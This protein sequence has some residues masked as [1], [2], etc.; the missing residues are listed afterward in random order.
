MCSK[1]TSTNDSQGC[2]IAYTAPSR[3]P[4]SDFPLHVHLHLYAIEEMRHPNYRLRHEVESRELTFLNV[5]D[6]YSTSFDGSSQDIALIVGYVT[7]TISFSAIGL[8]T[9]RAVSSCHEFCEWKAVQILMPAVSLYMAVE[10][11]TLAIYT[12][13]ATIPSSWAAFLYLLEALV[14]PSIIL[15]TF[16]L[17]FLTYRIRSMPFCLVYRG[18][19]AMMTHCNGN[20]GEDDRIAVEP[21][22]RPQILVYGMRL[23][24]LCLLICSLMVNFDVLWSEQNLA[25]RTGWATVVN[26]LGDSSVTQVALALLPMA[27]TTCCCFYFALIL[28]KYGCELSLTIYS[29]F[30]NP[31]M[32]PTI[33]VIAMSAGQLVGSRFFPILSNTGICI[34]MMSMA[35]ILYEIRRDIAQS[36]DLGNFLG[37]VW[38]EPDPTKLRKKDIGKGNIICVPTASTETNTSEPN[39]FSFSLL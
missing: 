34:Y 20:G 28:W 11:A 19:E 15:F 37:A 18:R 31:W 6:A 10:C 3:L 33:G 13:T 25:G 16:V 21:L 12:Y 38:T 32:C 24:S 14:A 1:E 17:T 8:V 36:A 39:P 29:S 22:V 2:T 23:F 7:L 35:R 9:I 5:D 26:L 4:Q 27:I 30:I